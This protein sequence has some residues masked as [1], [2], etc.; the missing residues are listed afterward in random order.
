MQ[1]GGPIA[2]GWADRTEETRWTDIAAGW[3]DRTEETR[4]AEQIVGRSRAGHRSDV[5]SIDFHHSPHF[6]FQSD[7]CSQVLLLFHS[8]SVAAFMRQRSRVRSGRTRRPESLA[9]LFDLEKKS[10]YGALASRL[11]RCTGGHVGRSVR[12]FTPERAQVLG[13][14]DLS[15]D[16]LYQK[17]H[18]R[19]QLWLESCCGSFFKI[20]RCLMKSGGR[21]VCPCCGTSASSLLPSTFT[22]RSSSCMAWLPPFCQ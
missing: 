5:Y 4:C 9:N 2:A 20:S 11:T 3:T 12:S 10:R 17:Q 21:S 18:Y 7:F 16:L 15:S 19:R 8:C 14:H 1:L 22:S 13:A 6:L